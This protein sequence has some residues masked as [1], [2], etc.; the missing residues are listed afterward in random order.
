MTPLDGSLGIWIPQGLIRVAF[1]WSRIKE[2]F[3][4]PNSHAQILPHPKKVPGPASTSGRLAIQ[5]KEKSALWSQT[6]GTSPWGT[7]TE[8]TGPGLK[9]Q[10]YITL[11]IISS[12]VKWR[13]SYYFHLTRFPVFSN[14][15]TNTLYFYPHDTPVSSALGIIDLFAGRG[16]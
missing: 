16:N 2:F 3:S 14:A 12:S 8:H 13:L 6:W 11:H 15:F 10:W 1:H 5:R 9:A 7:D 4:H